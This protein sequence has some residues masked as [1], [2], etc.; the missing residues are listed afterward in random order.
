MYQLFKHTN[1][2]KL[3]NTRMFL[4]GMIRF[5][6]LKNVILKEVVEVQN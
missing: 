1:H 3:L 6:Q 2:K 4:Q 5:R